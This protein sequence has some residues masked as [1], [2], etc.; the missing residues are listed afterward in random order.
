MPT[1]VTGRASARSGA[2]TGRLARFCTRSK[3]YSPARSSSLI[4]RSARASS[5]A[6]K[7]SSRVAVRAAATS[8]RARYGAGAAPATF[9]STKRRAVFTAAAHCCSSRSTSGRDTVVRPARTASA[10]ARESS[11]NRTGSNIASAMP[12]AKACGPLSMPVHRE[13][14]LDDDLE[15]VLDADQVGQQVAAAPAGDQAEE[16][17]GQR[18]GGDAGGDR[19][20][21]AVEPDLDAAAHRGAVGE[22]EGRHRQGGQLAERLVA[23]PADGERLVAPGHLG[24]AGQVGA[25]GEDERLA[26]DARR[27]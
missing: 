16:A 20:V 11:R 9:W 13:R 21:G 18:D 25:H 1:L 6:A 26:G 4:S 3:A 19:A 15:G 24:H 14:V 7:A 2:P 23:Q 17:L 27:R 22:G 10:Q 8:S 12:S 5:S